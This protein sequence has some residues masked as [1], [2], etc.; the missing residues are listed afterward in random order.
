[1]SNEHR[2][3]VVVARYSTEFEAVLAKNMLTE[4]GIPAQ[5]VGAMT[6]GFRA[7]TPGIVKLMVPGDFEE[8]ALILLI[9]HTKETLE[10]DDQADAG[11]EDDGG[12]E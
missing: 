12:N 5:V 7:E 10:R 2:E 3:P 9:E 11:E 8:Q 6:A 4:A 1:M